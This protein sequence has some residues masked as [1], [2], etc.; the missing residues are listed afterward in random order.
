[1]LEITTMTIASMILSKQQEGD[2]MMAMTNRTG[3]ATIH[4]HD[5]LCAVAVRMYKRFHVSK[6]LRYM[7][8]SLFVIVVEKACLCIL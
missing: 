7:Q 2:I 1:M 6:S 4:D 8:I 5:A 3:A